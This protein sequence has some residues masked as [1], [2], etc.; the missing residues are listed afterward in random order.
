MTPTAINTLG[1]RRWTKVKFIDSEYKRGE[2]TL[3]ANN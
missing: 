2:P 3:R 1:Q